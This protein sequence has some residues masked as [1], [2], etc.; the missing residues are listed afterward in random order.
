MSAARHIAVVDIGKT[1]AK[2]AIVDP[3]NWQETAVR[4]MANRVLP[5]PPYPHFDVETIWG[6]LLDALCELNRLYP[7][8]GISI[9]AH[10]ASGVLLDGNGDLAMPVLDY[11]FDGPDKMADAYD[12]VR[13][14]FAETGSPR[15]P[16]GLNLGAQFF[17]QMQSF[18]QQGAKVRHMLTYPQYWAFRLSGMM[19]NEVTS[20]GCHTDLWNPWEGSF[21]AMVSAQGWTKLM[22]PVRKADD[23]LGSVRPEI[24]Q[25]TG[26]AT[27]VKVTCGI[28]D[29]NASLFPH[30]VRRQTPLSAVSTGTWVICM[31]VGGKPVDPDPARDTLVNVNAFGDPVPSARF[32]GGREFD[33]L[34]EGRKAEATAADI[35]QVLDNSI[36]LLPSV[37]NRSGPF[38]GRDA[39]WTVEPQTLS[40]GAFYATVSFYLA[41]MTN[42]CL[43]LCGADGPII[44]EGPFSQN[45]AYLTMLAGAASRPVIRSNSSA[46]GTSIGAAM[47]AGKNR[48]G[49]SETGSDVQPNTPN[50][51]FSN[52]ANLWRDR[53]SSG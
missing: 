36:M 22:A 14:D 2:L 20:L 10:G 48:T 52:Y 17:W 3:Q 33:L 9:T 11:E 16:M 7:V 29:S 4:T 1:N 37:E 23:I 21:S 6:F 53:V 15:L 24:A 45:D 39:S 44:V 46:T 19:A 8:A 38:Q 40:D 50:R 18:P 27:D 51:A 35:A 42:T 12:T 5:G 31:A 34:M 26:L 30:L 49:P 25:A 41:L 43:N 13:P 28:H 32:M 47:L